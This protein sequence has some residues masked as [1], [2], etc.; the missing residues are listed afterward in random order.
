MI[1]NLKKSASSANSNFKTEAITGIGEIARDNSSNYIKNFATKQIVDMVKN[2]DDPKIISHSNSV[3]KGI[4][5]SRTSLYSRLVS[6]FAQP[7][8]RWLQRIK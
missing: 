8:S 6:T 4:A 5:M 3:I 2:A 7:T 1:D